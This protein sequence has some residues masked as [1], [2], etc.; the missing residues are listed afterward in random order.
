[1]Q[2]SDLV[3]IGKLG[4]VIDVD[5]FL[6]F[7][8]GNN[9]AGRLPENFFLIFRDNSVR[10]VTLEEVKGDSW[11]RI[12]DPVIAKLAV[13]D[14]NVKV[15]LSKS[16]LLA[17]SD[18]NVRKKH[19]GKVLIENSEVIGKVIDMFNNSV[20]DIAICNTVEGNEI[21]IPMVDEYVS[22]INETCIH[23]HNIKELKEL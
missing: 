2:I 21:M 22:K 1:M 18:E 19:I 5:C 11:I 23:V 12:D 4:K 20:Y 9:F 7:K 6:Q 16:E 13:E 10:Y 3:A 17:F 8:P 15:M 14:G